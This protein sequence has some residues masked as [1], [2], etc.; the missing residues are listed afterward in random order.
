M[1]HPLHGQPLKLV[2]N[3]IL[4]YYIR[5]S[6]HI[7][8]KLE[9]F[10]YI[11]SISWRPRKINHVIQSEFKGLKTKRTNGLNLSLRAREN[12]MTCP[13]SIRHVGN[14]M[15]QIFS[16]LLL[17]VPFKLSVDSLMSTLGKPMHLSR[18]IN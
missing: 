17:I 1:Y 18:F 16:L 3:M 13:P 11:P 10:L 12:E 9:I 5:P 7:I 4:P 2:K 15:G 14:K 8:M 6:L